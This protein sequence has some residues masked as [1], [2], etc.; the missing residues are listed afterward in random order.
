M[1]CTNC[2]REMPDWARVCTYCGE[3]IDSSA[4][5]LL[6][7]SEE[8]QGESEKNTAAEP[9]SDFV[10]DIE[11]EEIKESSE[12]KKPHQKDKM[13]LAL[14]IIWIIL[15]LGLIFHGTQYCLYKAGIEI[16][17]SKIFSAD[18]MAKNELSETEVKK[19]FEACEN[20][21]VYR[22]N[23]LIYGPLKMKLT[24]W[25][26]SEQIVKDDAID[27]LESQDGRSYLSVSKTEEED[28]SV[29]AS[30]EQGILNSYIADDPNGKYKVLSF[31]KTTLGK[32]PKIDYTLAMKS[33]EGAG[34][35]V[36]E[37]IILNS[38]EN[39]TEALRI[40]MFSV[41]KT[42]FKTEAE[43]FNSIQLNREIIKPEKEQ[44]KGSQKIRLIKNESESKD[45]EN[46]T[47]TVTDEDQD[48]TESEAENT[49]NESVDSGTENTDTEN[50]EIDNSGVPG[51]KENTDA[52]VNNTNNENKEN[53]AN[54]ENVNAEASDS[55][56]TAAD[57]PPAETENKPKGDL[58][59]ATDYL[60]L[61]DNPSGNIIGTLEEGEV[62]EVIQQTEFW[63]QVRLN[64]SSTGWV[65]VDGMRKLNN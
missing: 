52:D 61:R 24:N 34:R 60:N 5:V 48:K 50:T 19:L 27:F 43:C 42:S 16:E 57:Q 22:D 28:I 29:M 20:G 3:M 6:D 44:E 13:Y 17:W 18:K 7:L 56:N 53:T 59:Q 51:E 41:E 39:A 23:E 45:E 21:A 55:E 63:L 36:R 8:K 31:E 38:D 32:L 26:I 25:K 40:L 33:E 54:N 37:T 49:D 14:R 64:D 4:Q 47:D 11:P 10:L 58:Y 65:Y 1:K 9:P 12:D 35:F 30:D 62:Y 2:G 46:D 15:L